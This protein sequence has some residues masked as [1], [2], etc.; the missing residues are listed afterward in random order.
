MERF[1]D[2][3]L[4]ACIPYLKKKFNDIVCVGDITNIDLNKLNTLSLAKDCGLN[5]P[6]FYVIASKNKLEDIL[7][8]HSKVI[9][10]P[11]SNIESFKETNNNFYVIPYTS[12][13]TSE[14]LVRVPKDFFPTLVQ[15]Y[16]EP[17]MEYKGFYFNDFIAGISIKSDYYKTYSDL[18]LV[19][20]NDKNSMLIEYSLPK[21][22]Q[23][24]IKKLFKSQFLNI[25]TFDLIEDV[26][27]NFYFLEINPSGNFDKIAQK[28]SNVIYKKIADYLV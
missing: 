20:Q 21:D 24:K 23:S 22:I 18:K 1:L 14:D 16:I 13:F 8:K 2:N 11:L 27:G 28:T 17:K 10:K 5:I 3:E 26:L 25:G 15:N 6:E 7:L 4:F 19:L 9:V 12:S